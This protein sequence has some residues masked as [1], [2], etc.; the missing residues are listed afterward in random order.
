MSKK[1][2]PLDDF[3]RALL[4]DVF[5]SNW[6][7][8][9]PKEIYDLVVIGG[10][11]GGMTAA[12]IAAGLNLKVALIEKEH[13]GGECL[14]V[15]CIPSK[16]LLRS[17]R[18]AAEVRDA[19]DF[20]IEV[21]K[22]WKVDFPAVMQRVRRLQT[23]LSPHDSPEH[24]KRLGIDVFLGAARF[25]DAT[26]VEVSG[27]TLHFKKG[28]IATGTKPLLPDIAGLE[29]VGYLTNQ[30]V[31]K[32][33]SLPPRLAVIGG[34]PISCELSQAFL[35]FGSRVTLIT[36]GAHLLPKDD[37][38]ATERL[39][40]VF[41]G[42][43][44]EI[45]LQTQVKHVEKKGKEKILHLDT[46]KA[47]PFDE[48]L[49]AIGR[50]PCVEGLDLEKAGV[51]YDL[52]NGIASDDTLKTNNPNIY[53]VGDVGSRYKFTHISKE[54]GKMAVLNAL[55]EGKWKR[56]SLVVPWST[57]TDPEIAHVGLQE[58]EAQEKGI[59]VQTL[60]TEM[61]DIDRAI[62]DGE[63]VGFVKIHMQAGTGQILGGTIM[64]KHGGDMISELAVAIAS[65]KGITTLAEAIHP[66]PTQAE[67]IRTAAA[68]LVKSLANKSEHFQRKI[69]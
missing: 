25:T 45:F 43:G 47:V 22:G 32:L 24:F 6:K 18:C 30:T 49:V 36:R 9:Q 29:E 51:K 26:G 12:T 57:Y 40:K 39:Q 16:A 61:K 69:A 35:R 13:L 44:M 41:E 28:I 54:L 5:P 60:V 15:G 66:F 8:P 68:A 21:P 64:A 17:S 14:N 50:V 63:T 58:K 55:K 34:G 48:I 31:F 4:K 56:S 27:Q 3:N 20:G 42:E 52:K 37:F 67:V 53:T 2:L 23:T 10:G 65:Q 7:N 19:A 62:L 38:T 33:N 46:G 59:P 1:T 11:P